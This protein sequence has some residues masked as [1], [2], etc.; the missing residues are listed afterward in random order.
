MTDELAQKR[1]DKQVISSGEDLGDLIMSFTA[2][3]TDP[4]RPFTGQ[5]HTDQGERGKQEVKGV[6][7]RDISDCLVRAYALASGGKFNDK[8]KD[9]TLTYNDVYEIDFDGIDPLAVV[10]NLG[11]EIEKMMGIFPNLTQD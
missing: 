5:S 2:H 9:N 11:C 4:S 10:Q 3:N 7:M 6:R 8:V 1:A